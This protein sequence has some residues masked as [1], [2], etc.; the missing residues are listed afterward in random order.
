ML[1][2]KCSQKR[3]HY[4]IKNILG[5]GG[6]GIVYLAKDPR[7]ERLVAVKCLKPETLN[8]DNNSQYKRLRK[9]ANI[10]AQLNHPN[11]VQIYD[12]IDDEQGFALVMEYIKGNTL[13]VQLREQITTV[14]QRLIWLQQI[15]DGLAAAHAKGLIHRDLKAD[16][17]LINEQN[18]AKI[19]DFGIAKNTL[20]DNDGHT[21]IGHFIGS[22]GVLS[23]EQ[24]LGEQLDNRSDL[25]SFGILAFKLLCGHHPFGNSDNHN[26]LV[27]NI[28]HQP[29]LSAKKL[30]VALAD[31]LVNILNS[32]L[33]KDRQQRPENA[34]IVSQQLQSYIDDC[35]NDN[36]EPTFADTICIELSQYSSAERYPRGKI[37]L[38]DVN[39]QAVLSTIENGSK[40]NTEINYDKN[41]KRNVITISALLA[42]LSI[43]LSSLFYWQPHLPPAN[44][45]VA[46]LPPIINDN[47]PMS[48]GQQQLLI[49][50]FNSAL[51]QQVIATDGLHLISQHQVANTSGDY[52]QRAKALAADVLLESVLTC[53]EQRCQVELNR[54]EIAEK[55]PVNNTNSDSKWAIHQQQIWPI[56][57]DR[58]YLNIALEAKQRLTRL[59]ARYEST[60]QY[61]PLSEVAYQDLL[62][63]RYRIF[64]QGEY[65]PQMWQ[66]LWQLQGRYQ[67]YLPYYQ[68]MSYTGRLLYDES[69][70]AQYLEQLTIL[71]SSGEPF[72]GQRVELLT[73]KFEVA[74]RQQAFEQAAKFLLTMAEL[75]GD[76]VDLLTNQGRLANFK[77]DYLQADK[78]YRQALALR[79]STELWFRIANNYYYQGNTRLALTALN[80]LLKLNPN[81]NHA[82]I[83]KALVYVLD[84]QLTKAIT[85]YQVLI[86]ANPKSSFYNNTGLAYELLGNYQ[87]AELFFVKALT[88][89]PVND[90]WRLNLADSLQL[91]GKHTAA[92]KHYQQV[93]ANAQSGTDDWSAQLNIAL[94]EI[95]LGN[96]EAAFKALHQSIRLAGDNAE[97][98][99][100]AAVVYSL[101]GQ[102]PVALSYIEQS[103]L[104]D[105]SPIWF[106]LPWFDSLCHEEATAF[107][108]LL[109]KLVNNHGKTNVKLRCL[110]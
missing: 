38:V 9:E 88:M 13:N 14:K 5:Q 68:L 64:V 110:N 36:S 107:N 16:N 79:P 52:A 62:H 96:T 40:N 7:L 99:F 103:L 93:S 71:L 31:G 87:Q 58:Q 95:Q 97:V 77:G 83:L 72:F 29:P 85:L 106:E 4:Q 1:S 44:L 18:I 92:A 51:Q 105:M 47:S 46:V 78:Y 21:E 17:I 60:S 48:T 43:T 30:N 26:V 19:T 39:Q 98:L 11:I 32:L 101:A 81:D 24:A 37:N 69:G 73:G 59:F 45:Y 35:Q 80:S 53:E 55:K 108:Q 3:G 100:N 75:D 23:P 42:L 91:Q 104:L 82:L 10:L 94:A 102:W 66:K 27:Q 57:I 12:I 28:L 70:E 6:M 65:T 20:N 74:L 90:S 76:K 109:T 86:K 8:N 89:N 50:T 2:E 25:F 56:V 41:N 54:I 63:Y 49:E 34:N 61:N 33:M 67:H 15:A 84:G 22:Y